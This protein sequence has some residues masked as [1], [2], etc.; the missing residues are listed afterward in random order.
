MDELQLGS[1]LMVQGYWAKP[2]VTRAIRSWLSKYGSSSSVAPNGTATPRL[3]WWWLEASALNRL[4]A[5]SKGY[6][7]QFYLFSGPSVRAAC[8]HHNRSALASH[9]CRVPALLHAMIQHPMRRW[10]LWLDTDAFVRNMRLSF[11]D[12]LSAASLTNQSA[13][14]WA[15]RCAPTALRALA[16]GPQAARY[17]MYAWVNSH[18]GCAASTGTFILRRH[19]TAALGL[20]MRWWASASR[21]KLEC[22]QPHDQGAFLC[23]E[24][25]SP[26][27]QA[28]ALP[29]VYP[30]SLRVA[31]WD[32]G[33]HASAGPIVSS[34]CHAWCM[35]RPVSPSSPSRAR[36]PYVRRCILARRGR[37]PE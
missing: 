18:W 9:W 34:Q 1:V 12:F 15:R 19:G 21:L 31:Q 26:S 10:V 6:Q 23:R 33:R 4:Y 24:L 11:G 14:Y 2:S 37:R 27:S 25:L 8:F 20:L 5:E 3:P 22:G 7:T 30:A 17:A 16:T 13:R 29:C 35:T 36:P 28:P 32:C